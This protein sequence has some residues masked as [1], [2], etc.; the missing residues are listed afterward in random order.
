MQHPISFEDQKFLKLM[1]EKSR[2]VGQHYKIPLPL[3]DRSVELP[4]NRN[5][6]EKRLHCLKSRSIRRP[7]FFANYKGFIED[8]LVKRYTKK[9]REKVPD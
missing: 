9:S 6:A 7:E 4:N 1:N 3:K 5:T 2:K 8:L